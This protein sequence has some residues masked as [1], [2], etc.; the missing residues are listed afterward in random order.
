[1]S[2]GTIRQLA[3][4]LES[5]P[6][7]VL[8]GDNYFECDLAALAASHR[9]THA[10]AT[11]GLVHRDD[12]TTSGIVDVAPDGRVRRFKEKPSP[13]ETFSHLVNAG[14]YVLSPGVLPLMPAVTPCDFGRDAFPA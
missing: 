7:F 1:G 4:R 8:Y 11:I 13:E 2:A 6:F 3:Q 9:E 10:L 12:V 5:E 14:V